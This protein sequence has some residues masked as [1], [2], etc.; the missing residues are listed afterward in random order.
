MIL[1]ILDTVVV[2]TM[3]II[4]FLINIV[5]ELLFPM[6]MY[7]IFVSIHRNAGICTYTVLH[8]YAVYP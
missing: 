6:H 7:S 3:T 8:M 1:V 2:S 5:A 4:I